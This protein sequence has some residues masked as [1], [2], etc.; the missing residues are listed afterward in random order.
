MVEGG[1]EDSPGTHYVSGARDQVTLQL[2]VLT[3]MNCGAHTV[4]KL[5]IRY[6]IA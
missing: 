6:A 2:T 5:A 4:E 3:R 1:E